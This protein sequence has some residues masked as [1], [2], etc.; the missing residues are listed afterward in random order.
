MMHAAIIRNHKTQRGSPVSG[1]MERTAERGIQPVYEL[2]VST[3]II[4][5]RIPRNIL[6][7]KQNLNYGNFRMERREW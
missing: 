2:C 3:Q 5:K 6:F 4:F 7:E 1:Q